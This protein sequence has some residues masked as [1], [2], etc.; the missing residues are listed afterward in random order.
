MSKAMMAAA[1]ALLAMATT[2]SAATTLHIDGGAAGDIPGGAA[3]ND[4]LSS[5]L[6]VSLGFSSPTSGYFGSSISL[7]GWNSG[8]VLQ[9]SVL[10]YEAGYHNRFTGLG[11]T[12]TSPGGSMFVDSLASW[13]YTPVADGDLTFEF[14]SITSGQSVANGDT[15]APTGMNFFATFGPGYET[16]TSGS[17][18]WLFLDDDGAGPDDNHDDLVVRIAAVPLP[19]GGL[20]LLTGLGVL[21]LR[22]KRKAA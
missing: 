21:A 2:A 1:A 3:T 12:Y 17:V 14:D 8:A 13:I 18:L 7:S 5:P 4:F 16:D 10:G 15:N 6:G 9:V 22:R 20:M 11:G 19:A